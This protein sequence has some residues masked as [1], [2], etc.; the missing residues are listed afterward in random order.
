[1]PSI[2][3]DLPT[4]EDQLELS[5]QVK[6]LSN[7]VLSCSTPHVI[8]IHGDWGSGKTSFMRQ[9]QAKIGGQMPTDAS[10]LNCPD[11]VVDEKTKQLQKKCVTVWF[12]AWRYQNEP[13]PVVALL[14]EMRRQIRTS[15]A[16]MNKLMKLG[17]IASASIIDNLSAIGKT[18][19]LDTLPDAEKI[20]KRGQQW[21][22]D[23]FYDALATNSIRE[24]LSET[25]KSILPLET[26]RVVIFIDDLDRCSPKAAIRLLEGLK[27][28]LTVPKCVF[29]LGMN[30]R[31]MVDAIQEELSNGK[32]VGNDDLRLRAG[33]YLEKICTDIYRLP[34]PESPVRLL[35]HWIENSD[36]QIALQSAIGE[37]MCLPPNPR[38]LKAL[39]N[40]WPRFA[41]CE[42]FPRENTL[43]QDIWAVRIL[44]VCYFHQFHRDLW[45]RWHYSPDFWEE[46]LTYCD[47]TN[48]SPDWAGGLKRTYIPNVGDDQNPAK[49]IHPNPGDIDN[50]WIGI[51]IHKYRIH[52]KSLDFQ[53]LISGRKI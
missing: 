53:N 45:E 15:H 40:Q 14:Q 47:G 2:H 49:R 29:I 13:S 34:L 19:S 21:E 12:D 39:A 41:K 36:H 33:H 32:D 37:T 22:K 4:L 38:R 8:G 46:I 20:E 9:M 27:I 28:Y 5:E 42:K 24:Q 25:I 52:L 31:V 43:T 17:G 7:R 1:M 30:E 48:M 44:I 26:S 10:V 23:R 11:R 35:C 18:I 16:V 6:L 3:I 50:F 51:L